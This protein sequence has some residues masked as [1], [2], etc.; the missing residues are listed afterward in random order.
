LQRENGAVDELQNLRRHRRVLLDEFADFLE[1]SVRRSEEVADAVVKFGRAREQRAGGQEGFGD[2][3]GAPGFALEGVRELALD[4]VGSGGGIDE[5]M[6]GAGPALGIGGGFGLGAKEAPNVGA[7]IADFLEEF[8]A[9]HARQA[10]I[11]DDGVEILLVQG[12]E[13]F[14]GG[15]GE[16]EAPVGPRGILEQ[17]GPEFLVFTD[18][19]YSRRF[20]HGQNNYEWLSTCLRVALNTEAKAGG[21]GKRRTTAP[22]ATRGGAYAPQIGFYALTLVMR[23]WQGS[24]SM[25]MDG[26]RAQS[27]LAAKY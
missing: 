19:H 16:G 4:G 2:G 21:G 8:G 24:G 9:G 20:D 26:A 15:V 17:F 1:G 23:L 14:L 11:R 7:A 22:T 13:G 6:G 10:K 5:L 12:D 27:R 18:K 3:A 25:W